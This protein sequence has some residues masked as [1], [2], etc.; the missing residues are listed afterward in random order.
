MHVLAVDWVGGGAKGGTRGLRGAGVGNG[1]G[2]GRVRR[3]RGLATILL[4]YEVQRDGQL[5]RHAWLTVST[6]AAGRVTVRSVR[7][8][9]PLR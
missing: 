5:R 2:G 3:E 8:R 9:H 7:W 4:H 1:G 6:R